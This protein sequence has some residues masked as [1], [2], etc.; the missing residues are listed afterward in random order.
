VNPKVL[1]YVVMLWWLL[2]QAPEG[3][4]A[5]NL[6]RFH[7]LLR[8][9]GCHGIDGAGSRIGGIPEFRDYVGAFAGD[10]TGRTYVLHVPGILNASLRDADIAGVMNYVMREWGGR[11]LRGD[12]VP[13]TAAEVAQRRAIPVSDI[14]EMRREIVRRLASMG[15]ATAEYPWP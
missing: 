7:F 5:D 2:L 8:C 14:V 10:D 15:I 6:A 11:S 1:V 3:R 13:F 9:S 12:F 4:A